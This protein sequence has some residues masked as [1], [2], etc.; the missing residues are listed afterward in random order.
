MQE[1]PSKA[2]MIWNKT[3]AKNA[4]PSTDSANLFFSVLGQGARPCWCW[5]LNLCLYLFPLI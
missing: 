5:K 3:T 1:N 4:A 2:R